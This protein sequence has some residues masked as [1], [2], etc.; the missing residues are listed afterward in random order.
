MIPGMRATAWEKERR[1]RCLPVC[2][3]FSPQSSASLMQRI[4]EIGGFRCGRPHHFSLQLSIF[5]LPLG[6][7]HF[8]ADLQSVMPRIGR[9]FEAAK[10]SRDV[11]AIERRN[12]LIRV[13]RT[14]LLNRVLQQEA[15]GIPNSRMVIRRGIEL[16]HESLNELRT[17]WSELW[18][19]GGLDFPL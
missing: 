17:S 15:S 13:D 19:V 14:R 5:L 6:E 9:D 3:R 18:L 4:Q 12:D 8:V 10:E 11:H 7:H 1:V 16:G 2:C